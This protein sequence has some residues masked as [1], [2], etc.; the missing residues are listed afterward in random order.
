MNGISVAHKRC[1]KTD[2]QQDFITNSVAV[3]MDARCPPNL[4]HCF[5][6]AAQVIVA[7]S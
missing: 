4:E 2:V 5:S 1:R 7:L 6:A 3:L